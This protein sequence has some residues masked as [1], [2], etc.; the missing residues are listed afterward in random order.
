MSIPVVPQQSAIPRIHQEKSRIAPRNPDLWPIALIPIQFP[1]RSVVNMP[2]TARI[3]NVLRT[4]H[5]PE[6]IAI[7]I[8]QIV[9]GQNFVPPIAIY[10]VKP[11][12]HSIPRIVRVLPPAQVQIFVK[13][14]DRIPGT[15]AVAISQNQILRLLRLSNFTRPDHPERMQNISHARI[16][17][18]SIRSRPRQF[19]FCRHLTRLSAHQL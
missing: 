2:C 15:R 3:L 13:C 5:C 19:C 4:L 9:T 8:V 16:P 10:I 11:D 18:S 7:P 6:M 1:K 17:V 12:I 14:P